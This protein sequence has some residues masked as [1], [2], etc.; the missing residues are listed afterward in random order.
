MGVM[1][2]GTLF[3]G[4]TALACWGLAASTYR[5]IF[6]RISLDTRSL[7]TA[8]S[9]QSASQS[10]LAAKSTQKTDIKLSRSNPPTAATF[11][12]A[13]EHTASGLLLCDAQQE[14][15]PVVYV[16]PSFELLT[17]YSAAE[18]LDRSY[19]SLPT[20]K[21]EQGG[22][23]AIRE[24]VSSSTRCK[25]LLQGLR[26]DGQ[27]FWSEVAFSPILNIEG[28]VTHYVSTH[29]DIS[30]YLDTFR[31]LQK[32]EARYQYLYE[33]TPAML[34]SIDA[35]GLIVGT[36]NY[37]LEKLGYRKEEVIGQ[38]LLAF[39]A[40]GCKRE[41]SQ[42]VTTMKKDSLDRDRFCQFI[43]KDGT[44]LDVLLST[45][46]ECDEGLCNAGSTL[47][48][49]VDITERRKA[50][51]KLHRNSALLRAIN[52]LPPTGIFVMDCHTNEAL[53]VNSEFYRIWQ[54]EHLQPEVASG[55]ING[56]QLLTECLSSIDL[57]RFV[58]DSTERDFTNGTKIIEDEVPLLDGRTLRRIY[59]PVQQDN[60]TFAY[61]YMFEDI[62]ERKQA[63][64]AL[65]RATQAAEAAN[66][67]KS[68]F[69]ANMSHELRSPLNAILGFTHILRESN[70][71]LDQAENLDIIYRSG[72]HLLALINDILDI[73]KIEARRVELNSTEFDLYRLLDELQQMFSSAVD[74]KGLQFLVVRS[75]NLPHIVMSDRLKLRQ[76]LI[77]LLS[78]A[79]KFTAAGTITLSVD[80][81]LE[82]SQDQH[83]QNQQSQDYGNLESR[84]YLQTA[85]GSSTLLT[86]ALKDTGPGIAA[87][88]QAHLFEA[89]VQTQSGLSASDGTGL[90]LAISHEYIRLLGGNLT[91]D[92]QLGKGSTFS[93]DIPVAAVN[94]E[95]SLSTAEQAS[96]QV[97][98]LAPGQPDYRILVVDDVA[99][100]RKLLS[101]LL[102]NVGFE[103]REAENGKEAVV[104]WESWQPHLIWMDVRMPVMTGE[105][106]TRR[107]K[108]LEEASSSPQ[109][110]TRIVA[111]TANAFADDRAAAI[112]SGCD[113]FIS[114]PIRASEIFDKL[115]EQLGV[116]Y[117]YADSAPLIGQ[118]AAV[119]LTP[120][121]FANTSKSWRDDLTQAVLDLDND[122]ILTLTTQLSGEQRS[123]ALA[124]EQAV[125]D[126]AYK[127]LLEMIEDSQLAGTKS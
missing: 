96:T 111:L 27:S 23:D 68:E 123:L 2:F 24:A 93:F 101:H 80:S 65:A 47:G 48:V 59:G 41:V 94:S 14:D 15:L 18:I 39:V 126:F 45:T 82:Q 25:V 85:E 22:L 64:Q 83:S 121:L 66:Q 51:N 11:R 100:N 61:L 21:A 31:A 113:D 29:V 124:I 86:F 8:P 26:K 60:A 72:E 89:F 37:W 92:S 5:I 91:V 87:A 77:N 75:P 88:D 62:T 7:S 67:A 56:E 103:V 40:D 19:W 76:I 73:S 109:H 16:S 13:I 116:R 69:L 95:L 125:A 49:L 115:T 34:H 35:D 120:E 30:H 55:S 78:N 79:V 28:Q 50:Q 58:A 112:A 84:S 97:I 118:P 106:A 10:V 42:V 90:G 81:Q 105:E 99:V 54:L 4:L 122:T 9:Y 104:R 53:F 38:P 71:N 3:D 108:A 1:P 117:L 52:N 43:K 44:Y 57:G 70:P 110:Q 46:A 127:K 20:K 74:R 98:G 119:K 114:K 107:I 32:S 102:T 33:E 63:T 6:S 17:D 12:E 36:S